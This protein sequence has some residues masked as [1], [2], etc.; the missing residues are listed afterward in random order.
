MPCAQPVAL[1]PVHDSFL[2]LPPT[3]R[4]AALVVKITV[5]FGKCHVSNV[6][7]LSSLNPSILTDPFVLFI[8][9]TFRP[10]AVSR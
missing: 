3:T 9:S 1:T 4:C 2:A 7:N 8:E 5:E 6:I 10:L